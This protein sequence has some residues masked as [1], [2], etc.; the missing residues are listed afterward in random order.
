LSAIQAQLPALLTGLFF[1]SESE[2]PLEPMSCLRPTGALPSPE[3]LTALVEPATAPVQV[4]ELAYFLR[5]HTSPTGV[6]GDA[7]LAA[8]YQALQDFMTQQLRAVQ[9]YRVGTGPQV[10]AYA[11]G[12]AEGQLVGF[13]TV[14]I[15]T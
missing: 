1:I 6:L 10:H 2:A 14:L 7:A 12:E 15:E 5:N 9:V 3:L 8:R 4:V 11:L 13:K